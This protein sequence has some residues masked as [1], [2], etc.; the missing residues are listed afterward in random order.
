MG[1][2]QKQKFLSGL[3]REHEIQFAHMY[4]LALQ[5]DKCNFA[6]YG[7]FL[8]ENEQSDLLSRKNL[9]PVKVSFFGGYPDAE[10]K[11]VCFSPDDETDG[12]PIVPI[13]ITGTNKAA[14]S[15]RDYLGSIMGL[16]IK[17]EKTGDIIINGEKS[18]V[19]VREE[20]ARAV[21]QLERVGK[22]GVKCEETL[23]SEL[24]LPEKQFTE[25]KGTVA[26]LRLD[27]VLA[28]LI[29]TGRGNT[30]EWIRSGRVF[31]NGIC[32]S[33]AD[34]RLSGGE[35]ISVRGVGKAELEVGGTSRKDRI[36][37]TLKKYV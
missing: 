27:A 14:I 26:S 30:G 10:R 29:G 4:D 13:I 6:V 35:K 3:D 34:M 16:G 23:L 37:V 11:M 12:Y 21:T 7:D 5:A 25:I 15:H 36:F 32:A 28:M 1:I 22:Y 18:I 2:S 8:S 17:R 24:E 9:L 19:F 20:I 33:K 31:V